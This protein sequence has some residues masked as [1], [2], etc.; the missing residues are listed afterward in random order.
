MAAKKK[1]G[2]RKKRRVSWPVRIALTLVAAVVLG[3]GY[4]VVTWPDVDAMKSGP[5]RTSAFIASTPGAKQRWLPYAMI[6]DDMKVAVVA[7]EDTTF[8]KHHG[9]DTYEIGEALKDALF[10]G[11]GL[12]G[13]STISQQ[14]AKNLWLSPDRSFVRKLKE[15]V[16]TWQLE[17]ALSK[18]RILEI[19]LN[20]A[21]F[22][23][24]VYGVEAAS[25]KYYGHSAASLS[26]NEAARLAAGL[27][28]GAWNPSQT[29]EAYL[30]SV[31]RLERRMKRLAWLR[32]LI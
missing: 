12:R 28:R 23:P 1:R 2:K 25:Q 16:L 17:R 6:D 3:V 5:V 18:E 9:F 31:E 13:A 27:P 32:D 11:D 8:Y 15:A 24:G 7:A 19:Y 14:V 30:Q 20:V 26:V 10:G 4:V 29:S 22:G 21:E